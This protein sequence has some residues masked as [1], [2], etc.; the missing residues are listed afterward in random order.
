MKLGRYFQKC[1]NK[2]K[3]D[4]EWISIGEIYQWTPLDYAVHFPPWNE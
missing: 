4:G 1:P 2:Y 3:G